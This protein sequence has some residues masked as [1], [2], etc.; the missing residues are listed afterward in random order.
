MDTSIFKAYDIRGL[1]LSQLNRQDAFVISRAFA[2]FVKELYASENPKVIV[3]YDI[4]E[5]SK[6]IFEAVVA[7]LSAENC[8]AISIGLCSTPLNYFANWH[9]RADA[10]VMIT[11]SHNPKE[12][13][14]LKLSLR[15]VMALSEKNGVEAIKR[16]S[17]NTGRE[18]DDFKGDYQPKE[19]EAIKQYLNFLIDAAKGVNVSRFKIAV[20]CA[21]GMIGPEFKRLADILK[22]DYQGIFMEPD[23]RFPNHEP[24]SLNEQAIRS[25]RNL[26][27]RDKF[28]FGVIFDGDG[29]RML[30][31]TEKG[32]PIRNDFL[33]GLLGRSFT[34]SL[35]DKRMV[36]DCRISRGVS[37]YL[38]ESGIGIVRSKVGYP[39]VRKLMRELDI[40]FGGELS[41]HFF[42]KDFSY[43]E[44]VLLTLIRLMEILQEEKRN[45]SGLI[46]PMQ[47]YFNSGELNFEIPDKEGTMAKL[48]EAYK[49][50]DQSFLDGLTVE[51]ADWWF[52][53]RLSNTE[54][55]LR[56]IVEAKTRE[57]LKDKISEL[58]GMIK[59]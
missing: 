33:I 39:N 13:N 17:L 47:N 19:D 42:W 58:E 25:L 22:I 56:L 52:N 12:Y 27:G 32:E 7:G 21:N 44:S 43:S 57:L 18:D 28:D 45:I 51:C 31:M 49:K 41:G 59:S 38:R 6:E 8:R 4:R 10:S 14:G 9:W 34:V 26:M 40:F 29:D 35:G 2:V 30:V 20:N 11:A 54:P 24:N 36:C 15:G 3:G 48:K 1:W 23:G 55:L 50:E 5:S 53:A 46:K 37:E 16:A